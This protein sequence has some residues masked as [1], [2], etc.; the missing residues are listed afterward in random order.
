MSTAV[1]APPA[2]L[3]NIGTTAGKI[4]HLDLNML[5]RTRLLVQANSGGGKSWL[6]RRLAEQM[7]GKLQVIIIDPEGEFATLREKFGYVLV[8]KGGETPADVR[9]AALVARKLLE[10]NASAVCDLFEMKAAARH[11]WVRLFLEA[12]VDAPKH[13]WHPAA[14]IVDEAH[15]F[16]PE[17]GDGDSEASGAMI[18]LATRG[19]KRGFA[20]IFATQRLGKLNKDVAAELTNALIGRTFLD[21]DRERAAKAL[22]IAK[23]EKPA[24]FDEIKVLE[25][26]QFYGLGRA[27]SI[28][29]LLIKI[30]PVQTTHPEPGSARHAAEPPPAPSKVKELLPKLA[31]LPKEA[32]EEAQTEAALRRQVQD[33]RRTVADL[34]AGLVAAPVP[35]AVEREIVTVP[36][37]TP[38]ERTQ[39]DALLHDLKL[40]ALDIQKAGGT[41]TMYGSDIDVALVTLRDLLDKPLR[42]EVAPYLTAPEGIRLLGRATIDETRKFF[43]SPE[44][45]PTMPASA[46]GISPLMQRI[47]DAIAELGLLGVRTPDRA[48]VAFLVGYTNLRSKSFINALG[49]LRSLGL[50]DY[51]SDGCVA[52]TEAGITVARPRQRPR[53]PQEL[54]ARVLQQLTPVQQRILQPLI[55][56]YPRA[57]T[58]DALAQEAGYSNTRSKSF[59]NSL[60]RLRSLGF[61][62]YPNAGEV[63]ASRILF[64]R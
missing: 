29:R 15:M 7:F 11:V 20:A 16:A 54:Q 32:E 43:S 50:I 59:V 62:E 26:G 44:R 18:D 46:G 8:G 51:P 21:I 42:T 17:K 35:V 1:A 19:R 63:V 24:F 12:L 10:L 55:A 52:L 34:E 37:H 64:L 40:H 56:M 39:I 9:S 53:S 58:R 4:A 49:A 47:V 5:L 30:G 45:P 28:D 14:V 60:G 6:M 61:I 33:L 31:D 13:L 36:L 38:E 48:Q 57:M 41:L 27:I 22:G 23:A 2:L 3:A 25:D